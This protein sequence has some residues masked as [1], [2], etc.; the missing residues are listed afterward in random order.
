LSRMREIAVSTG[1]ACSSG[2]HGA[3]HVLKALG[4]TA[5]QIK[6]SLRISFGRP[7]TSEEV[8]FAANTIADYYKQ[9]LV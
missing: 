3:S 5:E 7:T 2:T 4:L 9:L 6:G 1:S 8:I